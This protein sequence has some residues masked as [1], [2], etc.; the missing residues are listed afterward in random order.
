MKIFSVSEIVRDA[1]ASLE[2]MYPDLWVEG[3]ISNLVRHS[4]GHCY[5]SLKDPGASLSVVM[6]RDDFSRLPFKLEDG[7]QVLVNGRLTIYPPQGRFQMVAG[8][9]EPKGK[10]GLQLA[11][12]QLKAKLDK[13]GL[14]DPA[15]KKPI[16][17]LPEWIAVVT[18]RDGAAL[19]DILTILDR[20]LAAVRVLVCPVKVQGEGSAEEITA[21][22]RQLNR[23]FPKLD[24]LL[25][26][27]GGGSLEDLWAFNEETVARAIAASRIP[28]ISCVGHETDF[29]IADFVA[30]LRAATP[31]AAAELV[32]RAKT[33]LA[34]QLHQWTSRLR[35][36]MTHQL[37]ELEQRLIHALASRML[38]RPLVLFEEHLL[39]IDGLREQLIQNTSRCL[40]QGDQTLRHLMEKLHLLS[41]LA[42][43]SRGY[44]ITWTL[45]KHQLLK[46]AA[47]VKAKDRIEVQLHEG[48]IYAEV[49]RTEL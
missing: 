35:T 4:S 41:P 30:D 17:T 14:F 3:E 48:R 15:R 39:A 2:A 43:L 49:E 6:F 42:T 21:A 23:D 47:D 16:P 25:V 33:E 11:F 29:T 27:R 7:L 31:S 37:N 22:I 36:R 20:R 45:P 9:M 38:Q 32:S 13:E 28:V 24:A 12:E 18:S 5:F 34:E 44:T 8:A 26:G 10:G 46:R 19:H 1:K 40:E